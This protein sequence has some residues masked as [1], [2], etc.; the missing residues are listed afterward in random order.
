MSRTRRR[1]PY[2][3][4]EGKIARDGRITLASTPGWWVRLHMNRPKRRLNR[5]LCACIKAGVEPGL[6]PWPPGNRKPHFYFW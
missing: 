5:H 4:A 2:R 6:L 3:L 1:N